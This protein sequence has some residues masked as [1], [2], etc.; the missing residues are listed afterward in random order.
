V[1][2]EDLRDIF[3][4]V[5]PVQIRRMFG[6]QGVYQGDV[7]FALVASDE[8]YLKVDGESI[9]F[10]RDRGSRPFAYETRDGRKSIMSYWLMPESALDDPDEAAELADMALAAARRAKSAQPRKGG[11]AAPRRRARKKASEPVT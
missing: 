10:F 3:R 9:G 2:A 7:M 4:G 1:D 5:G 11:K 6:G 8:L